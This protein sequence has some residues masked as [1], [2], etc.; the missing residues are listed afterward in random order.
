VKQWLDD[1]EDVINAL[2]LGTSHKNSRANSRAILLAM[3]SACAGGVNADVIKRWKK[4]VDV[5]VMES[6]H[7]ETVIRF[8]NWFYNGA[9]KRV[10]H[11]SYD[12]IVL[13]AAQN[14]IRAFSE[15]RTLTKVRVP[16]ELTYDID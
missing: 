12:R 11:E 3:I 15:Y 13:R 6:P 9:G 14:N 2:D 8:R 4:L 5:G 1:H 10:G 7:D 16:S